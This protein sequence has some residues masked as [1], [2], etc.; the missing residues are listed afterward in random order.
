MSLNATAIREVCSRMGTYPPLDGSEPD[1]IMGTTCLE[2]GDNMVKGQ[3]VT[4]VRGH[5]HNIK[6]VK[7]V[8][9]LEV[10]VDP[11]PHPD[12]VIAY[13]HETCAYKGELAHESTETPV[14]EVKLPEPTK[15]LAEDTSTQ[16]AQAKV[17]VLPDTFVEDGKGP[18]KAERHK[19]DA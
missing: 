16:E 10:I 17:R 14:P 12:E 18:S 13:V 11:P 9:T 6:G 7:A 1:K 8:D 3:R 4:K 15:G 2:C 19:A 5:V